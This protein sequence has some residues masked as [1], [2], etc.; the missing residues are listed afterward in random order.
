MIEV[1]GGVYLERC[2]EPAWNELYGSAGRAAAALASVSDKVRL[3]TLMHRDLARQFKAVAESFGFDWEAKSSEQIIGFAYTHCLSTPFITPRE[4][5]QEPE[6]SVEGDVVLRFGMIE[7][8]AV[9]HGNRVVYDPQA[10]EAPKPFLENGSTAKHLAVVVNGYELRC[11]TGKEDPEKGARKLLAD[12]AEVVIVKQASRGCLV[13]RN[14]Q[15]QTVPA[16]RTGFVWSIGSGDIFAAAFSHYW[17]ELNMDPVEA[18]DLASRS[19]ALFCGNRSHSLLPKE[20]L[21]QMELEALPLP[22]GRRR[23][24]LASPFFNLTQRWLVEEARSQL[25]AQGLEVFSPL[26]EIGPGPA[27]VVAK[28]DLKGLKDCDRLLALVDGGDVG[29][30]F[31]VGYATANEIPVVAFSQNTPTEDLKMLSG[32]DC[33]IV[34]DFVTAIYMTSWLAGKPE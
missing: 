13:V 10:A 34:D 7:S 15:V 14:D 17:G 19:T 24:Y 30:I 8:S 33:L 28:A 21:R 5:R 32:T 18:A 23:V 29:T 20:E 22:G 6:L 3:H 2:L 11:L 9:V 4:I 12:G 1:V 31:E 26:H 27:E 25:L 16:Y